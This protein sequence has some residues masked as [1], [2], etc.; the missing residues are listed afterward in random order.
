MEKTFCPNK[1]V[2]F[3]YGKYFENTDY[4]LNFGY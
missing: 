1:K 4:R 2:Q 3:R